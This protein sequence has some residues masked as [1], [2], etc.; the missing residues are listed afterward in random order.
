VAESAADSNT[1][2]QYAY[3]QSMLDNGSLLSVRS[4][5][6]KT[7]FDMREYKASI[8]SSEVISLQRSI[9]RME[10]VRGRTTR[11]ANEL[12]SVEETTD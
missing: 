8:G 11:P 3:V 5:L 10:F 12:A 6:T 1:A 7:V 2:H 4:V 9:F